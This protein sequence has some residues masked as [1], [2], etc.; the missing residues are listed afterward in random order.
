MVYLEKREPCLA[1]CEFSWRA[2]AILSR[3]LLNRRPRR[4]R[5][6]V[7]ASDDAGTPG[8]ETEDGSGTVGADR[9]AP[10]EQGTA[11]QQLAPQ[12]LDRLNELD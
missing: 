1:A 3:A 5:G 12:Q 10:P 8:T 11:E 2:C 9:D 6:P 4:Q 7:A